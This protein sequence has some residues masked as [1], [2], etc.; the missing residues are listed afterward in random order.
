MRLIP[1]DTPSQHDCHCAD[2]VSMGRTCCVR[3]T[4]RSRPSAAAAA[5]ALCWH[6]GTVA[7]R[8]DPPGW[9]TARPSVDRDVASTYGVCPDCLA[10]HHQVLADDVA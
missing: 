2:T 5:I 6:C 10:T 1:D 7:D 4:A 8:I 3:P 9:M